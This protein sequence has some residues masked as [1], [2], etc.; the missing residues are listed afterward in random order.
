MPL[1]PLS[2]ADVP[3][4][5][6]PMDALPIE[7]DTALIASLSPALARSAL[8]A[9]IA[10]YVAGA[11]AR[12][13]VEGALRESIAAFDDEALAVALRDFVVTGDHYRHYPASPLGRAL[14]RAFIGGLLPAAELVGVEHLRAAVAEGPCLLLSNHLSY[15]DTQVTDALLAGHGEAALADRVVAVAGPKVYGTPFRRFAAFSL[16]TLKTAQSS[17][18]SHNEAG[19]SPR[20]VGRIAIETIQRAVQ[21]MGAGQ[22]VLI[23]AEGARSRTG[24]LQPFLKGVSRY[25]GLPGTRVVPVA[26]SGTE[27][28]FPIDATQMR[29]AAV[30]LCFGEAVVV[31]PAGRQAGVEACWARLAALLPAEHRPDAETPALA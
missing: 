13:G 15:V 18:L 9:W 19:L 23:Y 10:S 1:S 30:R 17:S 29:P 8:P 25:V 11:G 4:D 14:S 26:I 28:L 21:L 24:R 16:S 27:R 20:E 7:V 2:P 5:T 31:E 22:P 6:A 3:A 12:A